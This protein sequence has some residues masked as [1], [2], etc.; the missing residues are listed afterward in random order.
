MSCHLRTEGPETS[1]PEIVPLL[2]PRLSP[3]E[4]LGHA[5]DRFRV[6]DR[7][8]RVPRQCYPPP[9]VTLGGHVALR[10]L[11]RVARRPASASQASLP[12]RQDR[13]SGD[14]VTQRR[15]F[16]IFE[17]RAPVYAML[18][19]RHSFELDPHKNQKFLG[20]RRLRAGRVS[21]GLQRISRSLLQSVAQKTYVR[22][23]VGNLKSSES[24]HVHDFLPS[25]SM[26]T[27]FENGHLSRAHHG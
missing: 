24:S 23:R 13:Y 1:A 21:P 14:A 2:P 20:G 7:C 8:A 15:H 22:V 3:I 10:R 17:R 6:Y 12:C 25:P 16:A 5:R 26:L 27:G 11:V 19:F 9:T 18:L 4:S